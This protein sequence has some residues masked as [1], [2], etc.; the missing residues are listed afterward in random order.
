MNARYQVSV[1]SMSA[2][3][4]RSAKLCNNLANSTPSKPF[5]PTGKDGNNL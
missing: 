3:G 4:K 5:F 2:S 1:A